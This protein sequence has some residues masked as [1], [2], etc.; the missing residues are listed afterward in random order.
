LEFFMTRLRRGVPALFAILGLAAFAAA[1]A[2]A[3]TKH[4]HVVHSHAVAPQQP[5]F[6]VYESQG[7][8]RNPG[9]DNLYFTD[10]KQPDYLVGPGWFQRQY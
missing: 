10:T 6:P 2:V 5:N 3:K 1:P 4:H 9:G 8:D 7:V